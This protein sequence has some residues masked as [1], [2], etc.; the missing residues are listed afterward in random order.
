MSAKRESMS[1]VDV[2]W[3]RMDRPSNLMVIC[4]VL[5]LRERISIARLRSTI[6]KRFLRYPRFRQRPVTSAGGY[7]WRTDER[8]DLAH[9]VRGVELKRGAGDVEL[10]ALVSRLVSTPLDHGHPL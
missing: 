3:L 7:Q 8:F 9:H 6:A 10:E 2:A 4:G 5:V 1:S